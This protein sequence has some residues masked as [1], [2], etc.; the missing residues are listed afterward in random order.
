MRRTDFRQPYLCYIYQV[1]LTFFI[2]LILFAYDITMS[3]FSPELAKQRIKSSIRELDRSDWIDICSL[4]KM[5]IPGVD[6]IIVIQSARGTYINLDH[7][8][9][10][11]LQQLDNI[12]VTKLHRIHLDQS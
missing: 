9:N 8:D 5:F 4:I 2:V 10:T 1:V 3:E 7:L 6:N 12:I 11:L